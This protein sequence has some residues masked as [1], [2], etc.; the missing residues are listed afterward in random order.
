MAKRRSAS[1]PLT[2]RT[3]IRRRNLA[4]IAAAAVAT[5][6]IIVAVFPRS[7]EP[8]TGQ[9]TS[10]PGPSYPQDI[11]ESWASD[12]AN[13]INAPGFDPY[14]PTFKLPD[15]STLTE[16]AVTTDFALESETTP[17]DGTVGFSFEGTDLASPM[18]GSNDSNIGEMLAGVQNPVLRFGGI[19][20]D[21]YLWWTSSNE[22][23]PE[24]AEVTVTP[25][26]LEHVA[27]VAEEAD[28]SV[29]LVVSLAR[30]D[31]DRAADMTAHA[32]EIFGERLVAVTVGN[33]PNGYFQPTDP[34]RSTR[35]EDWGPAEYKES[36]E[37]FGATIEEAS[38]GTPF[39]GPGAYDAPWWRAYADSNL[40]NK[41]SLSMHW[42]PLWDCAGPDTSTANPTL[43]DLVSP[44]LRESAN[45]I[46]GMGA[47]TA[48][49][50][51]LPLWIEETGPTSCPG[52][53]ETSRTHAQALWTTDY[54]LT[55]AQL[56]AERIAFHSTLMACEG[57]APMSPVCA[58]GSYGDPG[59]LLEGRTSYLALMQL[60]WIPEG[61]MLSPT[62]DGD[63]T[64]MVHAVLG[65]DG[66]ITVVISDLRDP[67]S[68]SNA[69]PVEVA[70]PE[71]LDQDAPSS[72][73][74]VS[75]SQL[76]G[77]ALS[78]QASTLSALVPVDHEL[79]ALEL[80]S[81]QTLTVA[82]EPG[83]TTMLVLEPTSN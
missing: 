34:E 80:S 64:I 73:S 25:E 29:S 83:S 45:K 8:H 48:A 44:Q 12:P 53:N 10:T 35:G 33:E 16:G 51:G 74:P 62:V 20:G 59:V 41:Q 38:P 18:W 24:W 26:N 39:S 72:W 77:D 75:G 61:V 19:R 32:R 5:L 71:G 54:V 17:F 46:V 22:P 21:K 6:I 36:L 27:A 11:E 76:S 60:S 23:M 2:E 42:Y 68:T 37:E 30:E 67:A 50:Y 31:A 9:S 7:D 79:A 65:N 4:I 82:S 78:A 57:G 81:N 63:G 70:A 13:Q 28:A 14:P 49:E 40:P 3:K 15:A 52:G 56:G 69:I 55:A 1:L 58:T 66:S 47:A 43:E